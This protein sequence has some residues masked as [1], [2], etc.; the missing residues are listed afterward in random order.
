MP[1]LRTNLMSVAKI[2]DKGYKVVFNKHGAEVT[3]E[4]DDVIMFAKR[5]GDLYFV[6]EENEQATVRR[7]S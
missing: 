1:D 3:R 4:N 6:C 7:H 5:I 2:T